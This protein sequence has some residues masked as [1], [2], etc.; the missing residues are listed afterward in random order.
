MPTRLAQLMILMLS[1]I[2]PPPVGES[3]LHIPREMVL[4]PG[5]RI[6][7]IGDSITAEGGYLKIVEMT[8]Q[9][10]YPDLDLPPIV[11][12][13]ISAEKAEDL[14]RRF[15]RDVLARKP[16]VVTINVGI[17]DVWHRYPMR[18]DPRVLAAYWT[19]VA[20]MVDLAEAAGIRVILLTPTIIGED[21]EGGENQRLRIY[22]EAMKQI[23]R[24]RKTTLVDLYRMFVTALR[25]RPSNL[26]VGDFWLTRDGV[27]MDP[28]GDALMAIGLLRALGVPEA[29]IAAA[30]T[31]LSR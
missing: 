20:Q 17:N 16:A 14:A 15:K 28:P 21:P 11:N 27:H 19:N 18:H 26:P 8:L 24:E 9:A 23:A 1:L 29:T 2:G 10:R 25:K 30:N 7:A 5:D 12:A 13:G 31:P 22:A 6:I 3:D 4:K